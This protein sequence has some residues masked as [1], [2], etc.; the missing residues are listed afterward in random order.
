MLIVVKF[1]CTSKK[2]F[3]LACIPNAANLQLFID[4]EHFSIIA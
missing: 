2:R 4:N 3:L 1:S